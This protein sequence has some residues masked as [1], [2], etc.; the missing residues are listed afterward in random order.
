[1][2]KVAIIGCGKIAD[3]HAAAV[4]LLPDCEICGVCDSEEFMAG[5]LA[6]RLGIKASFT[7]A[8]RLLEVTR[9]DV[10]HI[11]T[12][13][14]SHF[15]L[16]KLCIEAGSNVFIEKPFTVTAQEGEQLVRLAE[17][18]HVKLTAGHN[19]QFNPVA[20][21]MRALINAGFLGGDAVH[22]ESIFSYDMS[23]GYA[24][25][26]LADK[27]HWVRGL[28]GQ[29]LHNV[30]S[31]GVCKIA[32]FLRSDN[33]LVLVHGF[34]SPRLR[35]AGESDL[36][37][38]LRVIIAERGGATAY[39]TFSTQ[40][41]PARH[42]FR[43]F[44]PKN[45]LVADHTHQTLIRGLNKSYKIQLNSFVPP[46][47]YAKQYLANGWGNIGGFVRRNFHIDAGRRMLLAAF[48]RSI[49][50]GTPVPIPYRE[51]LLT[52]KIMDSIFA[53]LRE[54]TLLPLNETPLAEPVPA[55]RPRRP[56]RNYVLI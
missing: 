30:I 9:P 44:G 11:T 42:E 4:Q 10:V 41:T 54:T 26:L 37:D 23:D 24:R 40:I 49:T 1:V 36:V 47:R 13:P 15:S 28:P 56:V 20:L 39:F 7:D 50:Q 29:L 53:Q 38:E 2:L 34:Q 22:M 43:I 12:P 17:E 14:Q 19:N 45:Y 33:P 18:K 52:A 31:H 32:E 35:A 27:D 48:Y 16:A 21:R 51:I 8:G 46:F 5:Q 25:T 6:E 3:E 55:R